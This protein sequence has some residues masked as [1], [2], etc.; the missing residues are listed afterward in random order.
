MVGKEIHSWQWDDA[1]LDYL[2]RRGI[3]RRIVRQVAEEAPLFRKNK[4]GRSASHL[5][6]GPDQG[7]KLW[8][9]CILEVELQPVVWRAFN[10]WSSDEKDIAW[11]RRHTKGKR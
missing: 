10:G 9:I 1:N 4:A 5:M 3:T 7:G 6:I 11:Y 2:A 8:T